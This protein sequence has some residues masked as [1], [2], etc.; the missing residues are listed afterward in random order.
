MLQLNTNE[1]TTTETAAT[2]TAATETPTEVEETP[3]PPNEV[4]N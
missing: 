2:E 4:N 3:E 1:T